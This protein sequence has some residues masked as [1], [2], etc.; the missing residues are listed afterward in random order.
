MDPREEQAIDAA[1]LYYRLGRSQD[2]V[3][4]ALGV[5]RPTVSKLIQLAKDRGYVQVHIRD[6]RESAAE[7]VERLRERYGLAEVRL[8]TGPDHGDLLQ[9]AVGRIAARLIEENVHDGDLVGLSWGKT[10][11]AVAQQLVPTARHGVQ[12][13]ELKGGIP[14]HSRR[15]REYETMTYFCEAFDAHPRALVVPV[16]FEHAETRRAV[17]ADAHVR[18]VL[19]LGRQAPTAIF[20]VG[21]ASPDATLFGSG[22]L[23]PDDREF[24][25]AHAAGDIFSRFY[26]DDGRECLPDL[27]DRTIA[28]SLEDL[29]AKER[30]ICV[31][32]GLNK[33]R[34]L[35]VALEAGFVSHLVT[36]EATAELVLARG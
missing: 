25:L 8:A 6:P 35:A 16:L 19:E 17:E 15:T 13:V 14:L 9:Q 36:D 34:A 5:S 28:L 2:E 1:K 20:T 22:H 29:R 23:S 33:V 11:F 10:L 24:L 21:A 7:L 3:A 32:A 4:R 18:T 26:D 30:R 27:A 12:I 31:A